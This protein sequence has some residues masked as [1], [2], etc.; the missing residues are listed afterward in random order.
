[1]SMF[2]PF[3]SGAMDGEIYRIAW[4]FGLAWIESLVAG[5]FAAICPGTSPSDIALLAPSGV[6][7]INR[8]EGATR[9]ESGGF[10]LSGEL[11]SSTYAVTVRVASG[12]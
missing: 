10:R 3:F 11:A 5:S 9:H 2:G 12:S 6:R 1:M 7:C 8:F 4:G